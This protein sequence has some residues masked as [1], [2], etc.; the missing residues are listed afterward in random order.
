MSLDR[1]LGSWTFAMRHVALPEPVLGTQVYERVLDGAFLFLRWTYQHPDFPDALALFGDTSYH[2]FDVRGITRVYDLHS[3]DTGWS[4]VRRDD[5]FW[6][7]ST[8]RFVGA[9]ALEGAGENS[10]DQGQTWEHDFTITA[11]RDGS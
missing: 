5:D 11:K 10:H 1:L 7:R 2:Y 8:T 4:T 6:Q 3:D 9:D